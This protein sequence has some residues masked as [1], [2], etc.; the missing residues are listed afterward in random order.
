MAITI[1]VES[2]E[3]GARERI[4]ALA[5]RVLSAFGSSLPD[6]PL[7]C[8]FDDQDWDAMRSERGRANRGLFSVLQ[9]RE[10]PW[11]DWPPRI[12][13]RIL[14]ESPDTGFLERRYDRFIYLH[15][16]TAATDVGLVMTFAHELQHFI[17]HNRHPKL[18]AESTVVTVLAGEIIHAYG[19][20]WADIPIEHEARLVSKRVAEEFFGHDAVT[21][22]IDS[23]IAAN[24]TPEDVA[25]WKFIRSLKLMGPRF[26]DPKSEL[27]FG[28][29]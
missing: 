6:S 23:Q 27:V 21:D 2:T 28:K 29:I 3:A 10:P 13:D 11:N 1:H 18:F 5:Q 25:D 12:A 7:L 22:Y 14:V 17:Q 4:I 9:Y 24:V 26:F 15:H 16:S 19:L 20:S 8:F